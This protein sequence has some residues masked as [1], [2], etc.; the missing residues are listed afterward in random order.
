VSQGAHIPPEDR[1][2]HLDGCD[3]GEGQKLM[4]AKEYYQSCFLERQNNGVLPEISNN[5]KQSQIGKAVKW[6]GGPRHPLVCSSATAIFDPNSVLERGTEKCACWEYDDTVHTNNLLSSSGIFVSRPID[7]L[8]DPEIYLHN[9]DIIE[10]SNSSLAFSPPLSV[11]TN[12]LKGYVLEFDQNG[13]VYSEIPFW[14]FCNAGNLEIDDQQQHLLLLTKS[15]CIQFINS[16]SN[17]RLEKHLN[18]LMKIIQNAWLVVSNEE[19]IPIWY[20]GKNVNT[21]PREVRKYYALFDEFKN[22]IGPYSRIQQNN[23]SSTIIKKVLGMGFFRD[24]GSN[25]NYSIQNPL[26]ANESFWIQINYLH[27]YQITLSTDDA[28]QLEI[29][30]MHTD[31]VVETHNFTLQQDAVQI[32]VKKTDGLAS[33][34]YYVKA[35]ANS[36]SNNFQSYPLG[37][38]HQYFKVV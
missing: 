34:N 18:R 3:C 12:G 21:V 5:V 30:S 38:G 10:I 28:I 31:I 22:I 27:A 9:S 17:R 4:T 16:N 15:S 29:I 25:N 8:K 1:A 23:S 35:T 20:Y 11:F 32:W 6:P 7:G 37:T 33:G 2:L 24:R 26:I 13:A 19:V 36:S 14:K